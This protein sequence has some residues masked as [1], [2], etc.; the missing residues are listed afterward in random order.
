MPSFCQSVA[1]I[2]TDKGK[3]SPTSSFIAC[4]TLSGNLALFS[5]EPPYSSARIFVKGERKEANKNP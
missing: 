2:L 5:I 1:E 4:I 3:S